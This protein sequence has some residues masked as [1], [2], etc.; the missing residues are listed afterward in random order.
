MIMTKKF[1]TLCSILFI[2]PIFAFANV[3]D[4]VWSYVFHLE[5][6]GGNITV[7]QGTK[8]VYG[9]I[10]VA[11]TSTVDP[12]STPF[13]AEVVSVK[14]KQL[15]RFGIPPPT[16]IDTSSGKSPLELHGPYFADADHVGFYTATG[17]HLFDISVRKSS[18]CN[19]DGKCNAPVGENYIN[20]PLDCPAPAN[21]VTPAVY[22]PEPTSLP[23]KETPTQE[24]ATQ[25][26]PAV[27]PSVDDSYVTTTEG[28]APKNT[29]ST[30]AVLSLVGGI[31]IIVFALVVRKVRKNREEI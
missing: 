30:K 4:D 12:K 14:G 25:T 18:F 28:T 24:V 15:A 2:L 19:D 8:S 11:F 29:S 22:T 26:A 21:V 31:L 9:S 5:Y 27:V 3:E 6:S 1:S 17:K 7:A 16:S 20:C 13:Y 23:I 10:P